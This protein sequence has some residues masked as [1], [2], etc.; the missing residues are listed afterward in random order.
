MKTS[1]I[2]LIV[3]LIFIVSGLALASGAVSLEIAT[4][5]GKPTIQAEFP[6]GSPTIP[7]ELASHTVPA[8]F[9]MF[10]PYSGPFN[11]VGTVSSYTINGIG[12]SSNMV[13]SNITGQLWNYSATIV[14]SGNSGTVTFAWG[15]A[16]FDDNNVFHSGGYEYITYWAMSS[17]STGQTSAPPTYQSSSPS[18]TPSSPTVFYSSQTTA[19]IHMFVP[20][21]TSITQMQI[22]G[23]TVQPKQYSSDSQGTYENYSQYLTLSQSG[24]VLFVWQYSYYSNGQLQS[25]STSVTTYYTMQQGSTTGNNTTKPPSYSLTGYFLVNGIKDPTHL[26]V[27]PNEALKIW[28]IDTSNVTAS[29][30]QAEII[31]SSGSAVWLSLARYTNNNSFAFIYEPEYNGAT[32]NYTINGF[33]NT[34]SAS[35]QFLSVYVHT[36]SIHAQDLLAGLI[37]III[38]A[39]FLVVFA[40][41][42]YI[43]H[44]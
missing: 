27:T 5:N 8:W 21:L 11:Q 15:A 42:R 44:I 2:A 16:W 30:V 41:T 22:N 32:S 20:D 1:I 23:M 38:G 29:K 24:S 25:G 13:S 31:M 7:T 19:W 40:V 10:L 18:G 3:S 34:T 14:L 17:S 9:E 6:S 43:L 36:S 35:N 12:A 33:A 4:Y 39:V 28:F 26:N 37:L